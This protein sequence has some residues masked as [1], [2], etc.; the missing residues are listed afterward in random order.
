MEPVYSCAVDYGRKFSS[1]Y[2]QGGSNRGKAQ[3]YFQLA[4]DTVYKELPAVLPCVQHTSSFHLL[5][6]TRVTQLLEWYIRDMYCFH[7]HCIFSFS[8]A[9]CTHF[10]NKI[11]YHENQSTTYWPIPASSSSSFQGCVWCS[12][13]QVAETV[14]WNNLWLNQRSLFLPCFSKY[15]HH[16]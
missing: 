15:V 5:G 8:P 3:Y 6:S 1:T 4:T 10:Y 16:H 2:S 12:I 14:S 7:I 13:I 11:H 9:F